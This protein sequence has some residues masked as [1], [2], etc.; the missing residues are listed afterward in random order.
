MMTVLVVGAT[1]KTGGPLVEQLLANNHKVRVIVR[2]FFRLPAKVQENPNLTVVEASLLDLTDEELVGHVQG[3]DAVVSCLGH[4][5][6]FKGVFGEPRRLC[7]EAARRLCAAMKEHRPAVPA[8]FIL[9][10]T[11]AVLN[12]DLQEQ[13]RWFEQGLLTLLHYTLPPHRDN[14]TA[15]EYLHDTLG[16]DNKCIEWCS[17]RPDSLIDA[18]ISAYDINESITTG[19]FSGRP[20]ARSNVAHFMA[21]LIEDADLWNTWKFRMPVISNAAQVAR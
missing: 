12:P 2:S 18:E 7:T 15:A 8:K 3:C 13:R 14:E 9:M 17:V 6:D 5:L 19:I 21:A 20:T 10:N 1:G 16:T 4:V 11:V